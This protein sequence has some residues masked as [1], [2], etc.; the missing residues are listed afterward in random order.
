MYYTQGTL[1]TVERIIFFFFF[2]YYTDPKTGLTLK[3]KGCNTI[4]SN[5]DPKN[6]ALITETLEAYDEKANA[7]ISTT[8]SKEMDTRLSR[9]K[10]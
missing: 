7:Q 10:I 4:S 6:N 5:K 9:D 8:C 2:Y 1:K 3:K